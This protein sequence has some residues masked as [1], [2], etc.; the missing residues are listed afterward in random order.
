MVCMTTRV[1]H[2]AADMQRGTGA[3][4]IVMTQQLKMIPHDGIINCLAVA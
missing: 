1:Q 2:V 3:I 4:S